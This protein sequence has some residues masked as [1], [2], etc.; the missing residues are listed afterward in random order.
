MYSIED[1]GMM[2][3]DSGRME[4]YVQA[5]QQAIKPGSVVLDIGTGTGIFAF[6]ACK[7]GAR[8]VYAIEPDSAV[9]V[10]QKLS[11]VNGF[12]KR[13]QFYQELST[14][15][16]L[17][18]PAD[19]IICDLRGVLPLLQHHIPSIIDARERLLA[20]GGVLIPQQD[21]LWAALVSVPKL[22]DYYSQ[23]WNQNPYGFSMEGVSGWVKNKWI[24]S[25]IKPEHLLTQPQC[26]ATLDYTTIEQPNLKAQLDWTITQAGIAHGFAAW[27]DAT[28]AEGISFSNAP[29]EP[30]LIYGR[31]YF[32]WL[33]PV[34]LVPGDRV[35]VKI[36]ANLVKDDY[37]WSWHSQ[38]FAAED[39]QSIKANFQQSTFLAQP[40]S[41][42]QLH[43]Q[44]DSYQPQLNQA[45]K[46]AQRTLDLMSQG[47]TLANIAHTLT[48]EFPKK[49][50]HWQAALTLVGEMSQQYSD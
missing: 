49:F 6:L 32:P 19:V 25:K 33:E 16:N 27:F 3:K 8:Q 47:Q 5:L 22:H 26:W 45:G 48:A 11:Q 34:K 14:K 4:P 10:A 44:A 24:K 41:P 35:Q 46:I 9:I 2:I 37:I 1:Y 29:G 17:P 31:A 12:R 23:P 28:L 39:N 20:P 36:K 30:D 40:F 18:E 42:S 13:I 7:F 43:K 50:P 38:V 21:I 15:V